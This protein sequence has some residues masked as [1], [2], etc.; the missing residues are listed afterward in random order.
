VLSLAALA[1]FC[2]AA[3][4]GGDS[5]TVEYFDGGSLRSDVSL[6]LGFLYG[7][8]SRPDGLGVPIAT[9]RAGVAA[10]SGNPAGLAFIE[11]GGMLLDVLPPVGV[12]VSDLANLEARA[13]TLTDD[14]LEDVAAYGMLPTYPEVDATAGQQA[15]LVSGALALRF[16]DYACGVSIEEPMSLELDLVENGLEAFAGGVKSDGGDDVD[17][18]MRGFADAACDL[19][20]RVD[21]TTVAL[22]RQVTPKLGLGTSLSRYHAEAGVRGVLRGDGVVNYGGQEYSFNDEGDPWENDLG[23]S[24]DGRFEG[25]GLGWSVG[26]SYRRLHWL[27]IDAHYVSIPD[28]SLAGQLVTVES[29]PPAATEDGIELSEVSASQPTLTETTV[30]VNGA[31]VELRLPSYAGVA[32]TARMGRVLA[33]LEYRMF[34]GVIGFQHEGHSEGVELTDGLGLEVD[35][36]GLWLGGGVIRGRLVGETAEGE[37]EEDVLIP[38]ANL[39]MGMQFGEHVG[40]DLK[41]LA[42]PMQVA[43]IS[44]S[45]GF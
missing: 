27:T 6:S 33:T 3:A 31:P 32:A 20:F 38:L 7:A 30:Q 2:P 39:G 12:S 43:R 16:G 19:S 23:G 36:G 15:G 25:E 40:V 5:A 13:R 18:E 45:Y 26:A 34:D 17:I 35:L 14:S 8:G 10:T 1:G 9:L 44:L 42:L 37:D 24:L 29:M 11:R 21:R 41:L 4:A 22:A 28:L